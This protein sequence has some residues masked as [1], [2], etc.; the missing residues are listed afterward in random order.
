MPVPAD[1]CMP[2]TTIRPLPFINY[3]DEQQCS[4]HVASL[5]LE[6]E[7]KGRALRENFFKIR[8]LMNGRISDVIVENCG[9]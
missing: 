3:Y 9:F 7:K 4:L 8:N 6:F 2:T 1:I 5:W